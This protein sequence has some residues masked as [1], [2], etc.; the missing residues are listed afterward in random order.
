MTNSNILSGWKED[1]NDS[2]DYGK[3]NFK[4]K[5]IS[6]LFAQPPTECGEFGRI[7]K[8]TQPLHSCLYNRFSNFPKLTSVR[9]IA[10]VCAMF[11]W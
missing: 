6:S 7:T 3:I 1:I 4:I 10:W 9:Y 5:Y 11:P 2:F 8:Q